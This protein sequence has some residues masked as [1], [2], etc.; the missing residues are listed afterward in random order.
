MWGRSA[1]VA[2]I[3]VVTAGSAPGTSLALDVDD[4]R[5]TAAVEERAAMGLDARVEVVVDLLTTGIDVGSEKWGI[6]MSAAEER[7][8]DL[9]GRMAFSNRVH[10]ALED[11]IRT[12]STFAGIVVDQQE[13]GS[14]VVLVAQGDGALEA[15]VLERRLDD[16]L[17]RVSVRHVEHPLSTLV[18]AAETLRERWPHLNPDV[19]LVGV[20]VDT[21]A[22]GLRVDVSP[23]SLDRINAA[24]LADE[25][26]VSIAVAAAVPGEDQQECTSRDNCHNPME[27]GIRIR[28]GSSTSTGL[29][30]MG[31]HIVLNGN[32]QFLTA[33]HC[34][35]T[36]SLSWYHQG[37]GLVGSVQASYYVWGGIDIQRINM[38]DWQ[39]SDDVYAGPINIT[40][41]RYPSQGEA[42]CAS[43]GRTQWVDCGTIRDTYKSW[44][45]QTCGC[46]VYG[47]DHDG[48]AT[49]VGDSGSPIYAGVAGGNGVALGI[50]D[51]AAGEFA[52]VQDA[53]PAWGSVVP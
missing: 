31:F 14:V 39:A 18:A 4:E 22:N 29:C 3:L 32:E 49:Q 34:G 9:G 53:F 10:E 41:S 26:G 15:E 25:I 24:T 5:V 17:R 30:T 13:G 11:I 6:P 50:H 1:A 52:R 28:H 46:P 51:T 8:V 42:V 38:Q 48:I 37:Y 21:A 19:P 2:T 36:G 12:S 33:G 45:S 27:A 16:G 43:L 47:A 7:E 35:Y 20:A 40:G 23:S 44:T